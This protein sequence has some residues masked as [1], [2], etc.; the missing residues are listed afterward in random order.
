M[1]DNET[2]ELKPCPHC[3][4]DARVRTIL[5]E[6]SYQEEVYVVECRSCGSQGMNCGSKEK[7]IERWNNRPVEKRLRDENEKV[8]WILDKTRQERDALVSQNEMLKK[9]NRKLLDRCEKL[10]AELA[11][12]EG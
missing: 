2:K 4:D 7:A 6:N 11:K 8:N 5:P 10:K 1:S 12:G 3:G 9:S